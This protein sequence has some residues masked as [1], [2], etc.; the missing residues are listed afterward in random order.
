ML[1]TPEH[2]RW[3]EAEGDRLLDFG[4]ASRHPDGGFAW[5]DD[6]GAP[7]PDRPLELWVTCRMTHVYAL[8]ELMGRPGC[9]DLVDH[10]V[11]ALR[12]RFEDSVHGGWFAQVGADGPTVSDKTAYEHAFVVLAGADQLLV[13][14]QMDTAYGAVLAAVRSGEISTQRLDESVYRILL[15]KFQR[16]L[17]KDSTVDVAAAPQIMGA[18]QR[19][20]DARGAESVSVRLHHPGHRAAG[21]AVPQQAPVRGDRGE[22]Y[23][24]QRFNRGLAPSALG[25]GRRSG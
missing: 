2:T 4:R 3:L 14:P 7:E 24:K 9:S 18:P 11:A 20:A 5:L 13:A 15:H 12:G 1:G 8:G 6:G 16:G 17:F 21:V 23:G 22:V 25:R 19:R 10:G